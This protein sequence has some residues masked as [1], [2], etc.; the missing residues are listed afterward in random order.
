[1]SPGTKLPPQQLRTSLHERI[2][3]LR[4]ED[5]ELVHQQM[6]LLDM[7]RRLDALCEDYAGDW[8]AGRVTQKMVDESIK[9]YR[10]SHPYCSPGRP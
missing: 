10:A 9:D 5:L 8:Q 1:M 7:R 4:D 2:D 3:Q 6:V